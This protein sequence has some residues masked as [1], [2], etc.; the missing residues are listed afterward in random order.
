LITACGDGV[1]RIFSNNP[2][3]WLSQEEISEYNNFC[4][5]EGGKT[6]SDQIKDSGLSVN[7]LP[8]ISYIQT[9]KGKEGEIRAFNNNG[10]GEAWV[11][12]GGKWE[13]IGDVIGGED[14]NKNPNQGSCNSTIGSKYYQGDQ[15][16]PAGEYDFVFDVELD[17][18][19]TKL[20]FNFDGN[21][22]IAAQK[23]CRRENLHVRYQDDI[24]KFLKDNAKQKPSM[25]YQKPKEGV[26]TYATNLLNLVKFPNVSLIYLY[27]SML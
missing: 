5:S 25:A 23:F 14:K 24:I 12:K 19:T 1:L 16:F 3:K 27:K 8:N 22:L 26:S 21:K 15:L 17:H 2:D 13:K 11:F 18:K 10:K 4:F 9:N 7:Q 6:Q 20:P